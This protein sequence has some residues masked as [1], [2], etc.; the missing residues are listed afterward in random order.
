VLV[1]S[2]IGHWKIGDVN[3]TISLSL[4]LGSIPGVFVGTQ[5]VTKLPERWF[6]G[7]LA[8][9]LV[10]VAMAMLPLPHVKA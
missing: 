2:L 1:P 5:F 4:L 9:V 10:V 6:R 8:G 7:A 3:P